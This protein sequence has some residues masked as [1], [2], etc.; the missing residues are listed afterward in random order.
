MAKRHRAHGKGVGPEL[1]ARLMAA[2]TAGW[3]PDRVDESEASHETYFWLSQT[4]TL[5]IITQ[6]RAELAD[7]QGLTEAQIRLEFDDHDPMA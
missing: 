3:H 5:N 2:S 6:A 4:E 1:V 7:G